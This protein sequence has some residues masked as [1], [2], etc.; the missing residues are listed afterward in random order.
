MD[1]TEIKHDI[2]PAGSGG[3]GNRP[4]E[5]LDAPASTKTTPALACATNLVFDEPES[6]DEFG[7]HQ[8]IADALAELIKE[9]DKSVAVGIEGAWGSGKTTVVNLL[10]VSLRDR[11]QDYALITFDAWAHEGDPLRRTFLETIIEQLKE[12][13]EGDAKWVDPGEWEK[14]L[15]EISQR[16]TVEENKNVPKLDWWDKT[17]IFSLAFVPL[18]NVLLG[19]ALREEVTIRWAA[20]PAWKFIIE[21]I[22]GV[23][24]IL[25]PLVVLLAR[26]LK[27]GSAW[28]GLN[29]WT[30]L[31]SKGVSETRT[32]TTKTPEPTSI[33]FEKAFKDLTREALSKPGRKII[34]VID[35]LDRVDSEDALKIW[36]TLQTFLQ[37]KPDQR[38]EWLNRLWTVVLYDPRGL[39][40]L[41]ANSAGG[42]G[43]IA[44]A[45]VYKSFV[46]KTFQV[47]F[48]VPAPV[49]SEWRDFLMMRLRDAF[50]DHR[51]DWHTVYR[52][53]A[54]HSAARRPTAR[55]LK[56]FVNQI[57][58][59]HRQWARGGTREK[60][61]YSLPHI[62]CYVLL[63]EAFE[64]LLPHLLNGSL[65]GQNDKN[66]LGPD[67]S[68]SLAGLSFNVESER[69][70]QMLLE[71]PIKSALTEDS[72]SDIRKW[73]E[74]NDGF[75]EVLETVVSSQWFGD[76]PLWIANAAKVL[77]ESGVLST[78]DRK[79]VQTV[80]AAL[81][82]SAQRVKQW[83]YDKSGRAEGLA[84]LCR[85]K[86]HDANAVEAEKFTRLIL[87]A[88]TSWLL[89][90]HH[91]REVSTS[92]WLEVA[93]L[94]A[95]E[96][97][98]ADATSL[99]ADGIVAPIGELY[100]NRIQLSG[101]QI[102]DSLQVLMELA[103]QAEA[104][105]SALDSLRS[106]AGSA[107]FLAFLEKV[108]DRG[109]FT[110][111]LC[112]LTVLEYREGGLSGINGD[113]AAQVALKDALGDT[114]TGLVEKFTDLLAQHQRL[115]LL[116]VL[117]DNLPQAEPFVLNCLRYVAKDKIEYAGSL[118]TPQA[119]VEWY[120]RIGGRVDTNET[121]NELMP[122]ITAQ[123]IKETGLIDYITGSTFEVQSVGMYAAVYEV[124][125]DEGFRA[126][127]YQGLKQVA[128]AQWEES[129]LGERGLFALIP[130]LGAPAKGEE[131]GE[132][133]RR[134]LLKYGGEMVKGK[135][136]PKSPNHWRL[137]PQALTSVDR[138]ELG[139]R[140]L[141]RMKS[142]NGNIPEK[143]FDI[144]EE[145][146]SAPDV[147]KSQPE[148]LSSLF[149]PIVRSKNF[150]A[151]EW[152]T[153]I[154]PHIEVGRVLPSELE[155]LTVLRKEI[156]S[157]ES[158]V[159]SFEALSDERAA[160]MAFKAAWSKFLD[161]GGPA[162]G[163]LIQQ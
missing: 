125:K 3:D 34:L 98:S 138:R 64:D 109:E 115:G 43:G 100:K 53:R 121:K 2:F 155:W 52:V 108:P 76:E 27:G 6:G 133:L 5:T 23:M 144:F 91:T 88:M 25:A 78:A 71:G 157:L 106:L 90:N 44:A 127:C 107:D 116:L 39:S 18:G 7:P 132:G 120:P 54:L 122:K 152:L 1:T 31:S 32:E 11:E 80:T 66:L 130:T 15:E 156:K 134:A 41:W 161:T 124:S 61:E 136:D 12:K 55:E 140:L 101:A 163:V 59:L 68:R 113:P 103:N 72:W 51:E 13:G 126:W 85:W 36:S 21:F 97:S 158:S 128:S 147:L 14:K 114:A 45:S 9:G 87:S 154:L 95:R 105:P 86:A 129:L 102:S 67:L 162:S 26:R 62:A 16:R 19:A 75:W 10:R 148:I 117:L 145:E 84:T 48:E 119:F 141:S 137:L 63:R 70:Y 150:R 24:F 79:E 112:L 92:G 35:N 69:G 93:R 47:R 139:K 135:L 4:D 56:L 131:L 104:V 149:I 57:G 96:T 153:K 40:A 42:N 151:I 146:I 74:K 123:V 50:P 118:F 65:P 37:H 28:S 99:F 159:S 38:Y 73:A 160:V 33:E 111:A 20:P 77:E 8:R 89:Q 17:L 30:L 58:A 22:P 82:D 142:T 81:C 143:F 29:I 46:D 110:R 49:L 94:M 83:P 60:D